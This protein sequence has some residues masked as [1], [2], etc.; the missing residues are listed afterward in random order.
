MAPIKP[1]LVLTGRRTAAQ[2]TVLHEAGHFLR[3]KCS[4]LQTL[5][6]S[7]LLPDPASLDDRIGGLLRII[8]A[9]DSSCSKTMVSSFPLRYTTCSPGDSAF[10]WQPLQRSP[11]FL[12]GR[13]VR[14]NSISR[15]KAQAF[16]SL[17]QPGLNVLHTR[18]KRLCEES[19]PVCLQH[20][21]Q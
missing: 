8:Q 18:L 9:S 4:T 12:L 3:S 7:W 14:S 16:D 20:L 6:E 21:H 1:M 13:I 17:V 5:A 15:T 2:G 11:S 19:F 10:V